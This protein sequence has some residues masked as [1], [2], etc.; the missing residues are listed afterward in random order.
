MGDILAGY[1]RIGVDD[2]LINLTAPEPLLTCMPAIVVVREQRGDPRA[3][4]FGVYECGLDRAAKC[5][6]ISTVPITAF[7]PP[8]PRE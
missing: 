6:S 3:T 5:A 7:T 1:G 4:V 8:P 2:Q